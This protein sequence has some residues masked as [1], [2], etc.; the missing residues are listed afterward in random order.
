VTAA[1][2]LAGDDENEF[3]FNLVRSGVVVSSNVLP[4]ARGRVRIES[5][6][7]V[8]IMNVTVFGLPPNRDFDFFVIQ[9]PVAP[10]GL[11]WYQGDI[12]TNRFGVG[13]SVV[14]PEK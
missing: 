7:P 5:V 6:G 12:E 9:R 8:E 13:F 3:K 14:A 11:F 4:N 10:F 1:S 2:A